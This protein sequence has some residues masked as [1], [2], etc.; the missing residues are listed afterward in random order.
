MVSSPFAQLPAWMYPQLGIY[1]ILCILVIYPTITISRVLATYIYIQIIGGCFLK[2]RLWSKKLTTGRFFILSHRD[3]FVFWEGYF[4][5][6]TLHFQTNPYWEMRWNH[7]ILSLR[8]FQLHGN[9][10]TLEIQKDRT[11]KSYSNSGKWL[12]MRFHCHVC[13]PEGSSHW[14]ER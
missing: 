11:L 3:I 8:I 9:C 13:L 7:S 4:S 12:S 14:K 10:N 5:R 2:F 6:G 1:S